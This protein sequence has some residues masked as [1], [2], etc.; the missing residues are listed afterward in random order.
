MET[1]FCSKQNAVSILSIRRFTKI[2]RRLEK[3]KQR[4]IKMLKRNYFMQLS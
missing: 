3:P 1:A 2:K 4:F